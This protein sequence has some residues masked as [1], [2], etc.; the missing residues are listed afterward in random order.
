[1]DRFHFDAEVSAQDMADTYLPA[2][3]ACVRVAQAHSVMCSYNAV[4]GS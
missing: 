2:F 1:M 4:N 3:E